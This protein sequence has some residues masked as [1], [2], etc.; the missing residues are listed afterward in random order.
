MLPGESAFAGN[1]IEMETEKKTSN[2]NPNRKTGVSAVPARERLSS[3]GPL[4][5]RREGQHVDETVQLRPRQL[6]AEDEAVV[7]SLVDEKHARS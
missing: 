3:R 2:P 1:K 6:E 7:R 4:P 5:G